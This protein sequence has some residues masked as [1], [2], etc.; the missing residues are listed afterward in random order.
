MKPIEE[1]N[2]E[3]KT[4]LL[5]LVIH[6]SQ[7]ESNG[8]NAIMDQQVIIKITNNPI[9]FSDYHLPASQTSRPDIFNQYEKNLFF[10]LS[11]V[12]SYSITVCI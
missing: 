3:P 4:R 2:D 9:Y 10:N 1:E 5:I 6:I 11:S 7:T 8:R 12:N